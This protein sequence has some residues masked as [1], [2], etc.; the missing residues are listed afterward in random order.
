[1]PETRYTVCGLQVG[2][3]QS[4]ERGQFRVAKS[5]PQHRTAVA[6]SKKLLLVRIARLGQAV[7]CLRHGWESVGQEDS[8]APCAGLQR[9][10]SPSI[11]A[12]VRKVWK[13]GSVFSSMESAL[14]L[15]WKH[16]GAMSLPTAAGAS[17]LPDDAD[18]RA[19]WP[20][21]GPPVRSLRLAVREPSRTAVEQGNGSP[22][23]AA[24][25][26]ETRPG[27]GGRLIRILQPGEVKHV[28][29]FHTSGRRA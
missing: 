7:F 12:P 8:A 3:N 20:E 21:I 27:Q 26:T 25:E 2:P 17:P 4:I 16:W 29:R 28:V 1:M 15:A 23:A 13:T 14:R 11:M 5:P 22:P 9:A 24:G 6:A 10:N 19:W 18:N